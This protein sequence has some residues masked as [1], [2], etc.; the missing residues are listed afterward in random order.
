V[1][2]VYTRPFGTQVNVFSQPNKLICRDK[3]Y[4]QQKVLNKLFLFVVKNSICCGV[5]FD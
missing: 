1:L 4:V 5:I 3:L 2:S